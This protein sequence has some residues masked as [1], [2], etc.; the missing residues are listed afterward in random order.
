VAIPVVSARMRSCTMRS[1]VYSSAFVHHS[2]GGSSNGGR[3]VGEVGD[4]SSGDGGQTLH[5]PQCQVRNLRKVRILLAGQR[6]VTVKNT[7][8]FVF[9]GARV[10]TKMLRSLRKCF[11]KPLDFF[12]FPRI[13]SAQPRIIRPRPGAHP[14]EHPRRGRYPHAYRHPAD[15]EVRWFF[16]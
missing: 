8:S 10:L 16:H 7:T 15:T 6:S 5:S 3:L 9:T 2:A 13:A 1:E 11:S 4:P 14:T 12:S